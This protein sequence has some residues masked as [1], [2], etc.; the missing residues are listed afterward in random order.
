MNTY[1]LKEGSIDNDPSEFKVRMGVVGYRNYNNYEHIK[2][3]LDDFQSKSKNKID[4]IVSGGCT[5]V[6]TLA[7]RWADENNI[8]KLILLPIKTLGKKSF[9]LRDQEIVN[10]STHMI[11]F[12]SILGKGTQNTITMAKKRSDLKLNLKVI[13]I[14]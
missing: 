14:I 5:G 6:D 2:K 4:L 9:I 1:T 13:D 11:A 8:P 10:F 3:E 12:P 7:E